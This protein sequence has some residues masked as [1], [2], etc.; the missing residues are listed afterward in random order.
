MRMRHLLFVVVL[1]CHASASDAAQEIVV[2]LDLPGDAPR[3]LVVNNGTVLA[4]YP[5][6][7]ARVTPPCLYERTVSGTVTKIDRHA[8]WRPT[9]HIK[10][11]DERKGI[12]LKDY[13]GPDERG[14]ALAGRKLWIDWQNA[15]FDETV[16]IHGTYQ[17]KWVD[18]RA[19]VSH[20][21]IR[22]RNDDWNQLADTIDVGTPVL[23]TGHYDPS[24]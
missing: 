18:M 16:R 10:E 1:T 19:R 3:L 14:N 20:D 13:Y 22:M 8:W 11:E 21:C 12:H 17:P 23:M 7:V 15:C 24:H 9:E 6:A 4:E 2:D 5:I